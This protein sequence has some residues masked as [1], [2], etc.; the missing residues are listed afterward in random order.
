MMHH[1]LRSIC[2]REVLKDLKD[3]AKVLI[4]AKLEELGL[5]GS[6]GFRPLR[7]RIETPGGNGHASG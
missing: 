3:S 2:I 7:D 4:E 1:G 5:G 6:D